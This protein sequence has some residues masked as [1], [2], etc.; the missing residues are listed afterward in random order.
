MTP[1]PLPSHVGERTPGEAAFAGVDAASG[2]FTAATAV[3]GAPIYVRAGEPFRRVLSSFLYTPGIDPRRLHVAINWGDGSGWKSGQ[4]SLERG[5]YYVIG[6][7]NYRL[8]RTYTISVVVTDPQGNQL[9]DWTTAFA[10][11][12]SQGKDARSLESVGPVVVGARLAAQ[13]AYFTALADS[14]KGR[15]QSVTGTLPATT[16]HQDAASFARTTDAP[17]N[18]AHDLADRALWGALGMSRLGN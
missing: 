7:H 5:V 2:Q 4:V 9:R 13:D 3:K 11:P 10:R 1:F 18:R 16:S 15:T 8:P 12:W 17:H 6:E 14:V